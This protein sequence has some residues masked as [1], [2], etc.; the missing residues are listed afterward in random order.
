[1]SI[2][3]ATVRQAI[4]LAELF[5]S[6]SIVDHYE[7][8]NTDVDAVDLHVKEY[9]ADGTVHNFFIDSDGNSIINGGVGAWGVIPAQSRKD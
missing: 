1:M 8:D 3:I 7:I 5:E 2:R 4:R 9:R 6:G